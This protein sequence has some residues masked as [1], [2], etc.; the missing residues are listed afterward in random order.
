MRQ[1]REGSQA[2]EF[3]KATCHSGQLEL[4]PAENWN[5][6]ELS[7]VEGFFRCWLRASSGGKSH[8]NSLAYPAFSIWVE[9]PFLSFGDT[10]VAVA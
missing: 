1:G 4:G 7:E 9:Q 8:I 3:Y 6:K 10:S 2:K 5:R